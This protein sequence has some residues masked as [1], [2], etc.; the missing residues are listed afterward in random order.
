[1]AISEAFAPWPSLGGGCLIGVGASVLLAFNGRIAGCSGFYKVLMRDLPAVA[2]GTSDKIKANWAYQAVFLAGF[3]ATGL[4]G[5]QVH[6]TAFTSLETQQPTMTTMFVAGLCVGLGTHLGNGCTSGHGICG[7]ARFSKRSLFATCV[8]FGMAVVTAVVTRQA[9]GDVFYV[10]LE[11]LTS[12]ND[13]YPSLIAFMGAIVFLLILSVLRIYQTKGTAP[14]QSFQEL[15]STIGSSVIFAVGLI[16]AEM[17]NPD[18]IRNFMD[19]GALVGESDFN[20]SSSGWDPSLLCVFA[21]ALFTALVLFRLALRRAKPYV[22]CEFDLPSNSSID[23]QL[24]IGAFL[25][26]VGYGGGICPGPGLLGLG[27][28]KPVFFLWFVGLTLGQLGGEA[29]RIR[30]ECQLK[31]IT[32]EVPTAASPRDTSSSEV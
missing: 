30:K 31:P 32:M 10:P 27:S 14:M 11:T 23:Q 20:R 24:V 26:G 19:I 25:F 28:G 7:I 4:A 2:G 9:L 8:F 1:M 29:I 6:P 15:L 22:A 5:Y 3:L 18:R 17:T 21:A 16:L 12:W 13:S